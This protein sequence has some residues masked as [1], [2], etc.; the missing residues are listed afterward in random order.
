LE[1][2]QKG[3]SSSLPDPPAPS[4]KPSPSPKT[5]TQSP[6]STSPLPSTNRNATEKDQL[7]LGRLEARIRRISAEGV[8][9]VEFSQPIQV[10]QNIK[11]KED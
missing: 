10:P 1:Q 5:T 6:D 9:K 2:P 4:I 11:I 7:K 3:S 8:V